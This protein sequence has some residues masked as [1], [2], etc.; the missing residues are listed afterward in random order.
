VR[1]SAWLEVGSLA[2][3]RHAPLAPGCFSGEGRRIPLLRPPATESLDTR[4]FA[5]SGANADY[6][7]R[8]RRHPAR[9]AAISEKSLSTQSIGSK[10]AA[11][12]AQHFR[13]F[14]GSRKQPHLP[15]EALQ[16]GLESSPTKTSSRRDDSGARNS[17]RTPPSGWQK[18]PLPA[19]GCPLCAHLSYPGQ[20]TGRARSGMSLPTGIWICPHNKCWI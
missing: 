10:G 1:H 17:D 4:A 2:R 13:S 9:E 20:R 11:V 19:R 5:P 7:S 14:G 6:R 3:Q 16:G 15:A 12:I 8:T 18:R